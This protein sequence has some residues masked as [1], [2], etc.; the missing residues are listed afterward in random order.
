MLIENKRR[1]KINDL[2]GP[3]LEASEKMVRVAQLYI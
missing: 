2:V 3:S 1:D